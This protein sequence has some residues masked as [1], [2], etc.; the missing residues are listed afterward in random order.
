MWMTVD[1]SLSSCQ[2]FICLLLYKKDFGVPDLLQA[3]IYVA[4]IS[5]SDATTTFNLLL[6]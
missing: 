4:A 2:A 3:G 6:L 5:G 1:I